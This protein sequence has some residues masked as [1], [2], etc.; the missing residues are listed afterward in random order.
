M[1]LLVETTGDDPASLAAPLRAVVRDLDVNQPVFNVQT[2]ASHYERR[3]IQISLR[4]LRIVGT[5]GLVGLTLA[6]IG[7]YG[8]VSYTVAR[9]TRE[10]GLRMAVGAGRSD[11]LKM[12]LRQGLM[13]S[14]AG[15]LVGGIISA[16]FAGLLTAGLVGLGTPNPATYVIVPIMLIGLTLAASYVPAR[17][18]SAVDPLRALRYE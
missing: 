8:L 3:A 5:T 9:R 13:L 16:A 6:L 1:S 14:L 11:V 10:I 18:A 7:L 12:V 17:R 4:V 2:L 15:I